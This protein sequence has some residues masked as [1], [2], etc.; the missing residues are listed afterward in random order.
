MAA[1]SSEYCSSASV[2][3]AISAA[4]SD[5]L[6][7][8]S[9]PIS[10]ALTHAAP[11]AKVPELAKHLR[12]LGASVTIIVVESGARGTFEKR[13]TSE[14][15]EAMT[16]VPTAKEEEREFLGYFE[17][18]TRYTIPDVGFEASFPVLVLGR[19]GQVIDMHPM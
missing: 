14:L 16:S 8:V 13:F 18:D 4:C 19:K 6:G 9:K 12:G 3:D 17:D 11:S 5:A 7:H 15:H 2:V 10:V 1:S